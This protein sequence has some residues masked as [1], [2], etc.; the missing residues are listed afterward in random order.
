MLKAHQD[1]NQ[2][3]MIS[4]EA[5]VGK[6]SIVRLIDVFVDLLD[7]EEI[8]F[9]VKGKIKNGAPA[10]HAADLLKLYY[11][12]YSNRIRSS[13]RLEREAKINLEAIW[14]IKGTKPGYKTIA[15]FRKDN[16]K[17]LKK[18]FKIYNQFLLE[19]DLFDTETVAIDGSKFQGQN[20]TKNNYNE[21]KVKQHLE[22][23]EK[24]T[25][26]YLQEMDRLDEVETES[27]IEKLIVNIEQNINFNDTLVLIL[28]AKTALSNWTA[29]VPHSNNE[30]VDLSKGLNPK[31]SSKKIPN[32]ISSTKNFIKNDKPL[33]NINL[34]SSKGNGVLTTP[35]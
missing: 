2:L 6:N 20:S 9:I 24:Q 26:K 29:S 27:E 15:D 35:C 3:Q 32:D 30:K 31:I 7:L 34:A 22:H 4:L 25:K 1:R 28:F 21:K 19:Q 14:L 13:R 16:L 23:I 33:S 8:G 12:G 5:M 10:F 18:V 17:P 11:Y